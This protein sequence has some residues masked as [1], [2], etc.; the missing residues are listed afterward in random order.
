MNRINTIFTNFDNTPRLMDSKNYEKKITKTIN[1]N[2]E[3]FKNFLRI[4]FN[5]YITLHNDNNNNY[6][7]YKIFLV[8]AWN[9]WGEQ[10]MMEPS[11]E[12]GFMYLE[13]F[14]NELI[15]FFS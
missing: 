1:N 2:I 5:K 7:I 15:N 8:N 6:N 4:Q 13:T 10:M 9:E 3:Y 14:K 12:D 11:N